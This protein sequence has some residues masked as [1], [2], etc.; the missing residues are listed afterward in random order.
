[1]NSPFNYSTTYKLDKSHFSETFDESVSGAPTLKDYHKAITSVVLGLLL[2]MFSDFNPYV[3][4]FLI[5]IGVVDALSVYYK[6][7][8]W[9][10]RQMLSRAANNELTL[11][12]DD[13]GVKS[14]SHYVDSKIL[15]S[16]LTSIEKTQQGWLLHLASGK[17][18]LSNRCLSE[19]AMAFIT[20]KASSLNE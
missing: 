7:P 13:E 19:E 1:M 9:L 18:Y 11:T 6:K 4:W 10:A 20:S 12:I 2:L 16:D 8:W 17:S 3:A 15:W 5:A 14:K